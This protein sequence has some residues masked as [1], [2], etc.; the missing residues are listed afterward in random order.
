M[1]VSVVLPLQDLI[2]SLDK[3]CLPRILQVYSG[4]YFQGSVY[5]ISGYEVSFSTGDLIKVIDTELVSVCC[6]D[7]S[8]NEKFELPINYTG[9][10]KMVPEMIP[11]SSVEEMVTLMPV[12]LESSSSFTFTSCSKIAFENLTVGAGTVLTVLSIER[13]EGK[14]DKLRCKVQGHHEAAEVA[15]PLSVRGQFAECEQEECFTLQQILSSPLLNSRRFRFIGNKCDRPLVL[16]P[17][18]QV[19]AIMN[20][21]KEILKFPSSLEVDVVD[22]TEDCKDVTFEKPLSLT[23]VLSEPKESFPVVVNILEPPK[24]FSLLKC[25]WMPQLSLHQHLVFHKAGTTGMVI[26]SSMKN[27]KTQKYFLVSDIYGGRFRRQP[28]EFNSVYELYVASLQAPGLRVSVT[29]NSKEVE[30]EGLPVLSVGEQLEVVCCKWMKLPHPGHAGKSES[31]EALLCQRLP[32]PG[33]L[34]DDNDDEE[35]LEDGKQEV[36]LP[37]YMQNHFVEVLTENRKYSLKDLGKKFSLPLDIK[38][39][40]RDPKLQ[41]DPLAGLPCLRIESTLFEPT[42]LASF[43]HSPEYCFEIPAQWISMHVSFTTE[44]LPWHDN[45]PPTCHVESVTEV[46]NTFF[47]E[48]CKRD[49]TDAPPPPRPPKS[50]NDT[51]KQKPRE[52]QSQRGSPTESFADLTLNVKKRPQAM[53]PDIISDEQAQPVTLRKQPAVEMT[54]CQAQADM[55]LRMNDMKK[56]VPPQVPEESADSDHEYE[57]VEEKE[58]Y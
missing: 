10:F 45:Q 54:I 41:N 25:N 12:T 5:D 51:C 2:A 49:N 39:V 31:V 36:I 23:E 21:R 35:C 17:V 34:D 1:A 7:I 22:V 24:S 50:Y 46:T 43:P 18:Y 55:L 52:H 44:P 6:E 8:M 57:I 40:S 4:V 53:L 11:Y 56:N 48:F 33:Y 27:Q 28:R 29:K 13:K 32:E 9:L 14:E 30:G 15:I 19:H 42:I 47:Y 20:L 58:K 16:T 37:L 3:K 26:L 38:V